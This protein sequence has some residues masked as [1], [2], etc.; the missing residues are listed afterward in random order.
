MRAASDGAAA[1]LRHGCVSPAF[2]PQVRT[3]G[4]ARCTTRR[5]LCRLETAGRAKP[6][7][8]G[9][10]PR[11]PDDSIHGPWATAAPAY[12]RSAAGPS[13]QEV[14]DDSGSRTT[15]RQRSREQSLAL[16]CEKC[17]ATK[18]AARASR[19][20]GARAYRRGGARGLA[21]RRALVVVTLEPAADELQIGLRGRSAANGVRPESAGGRVAYS[22]AAVEERHN[23]GVAGARGNAARVGGSA[24]SW[25]RSPRVGR[26]APS[27]RMTGIKKRSDD[28]ECP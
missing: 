1:R 16:Q 13:E 3:R 11:G 20:R 7:F 23:L 2:R 17:R 27:I 24:R 10:N 8:A 4:P 9:G 19:R 6:V 26:D 21:R 18:D 5:R 28:A 25:G 12:R 22:A 15:R 14:F